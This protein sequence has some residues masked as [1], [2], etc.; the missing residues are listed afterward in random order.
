MTKPDCERTCEQMVSVLCGFLSE[1][2]RES[3]A[4][5]AEPSAE[6]ATHVVV[7]VMRAAAYS[8][9]GADMYEKHGEDGVFEEKELL[10]AMLEN[11]RRLQDWVIEKATL[12]CKRTEALQ[13]C[14]DTDEAY[15]LAQSWN[16][17]AH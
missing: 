11:S 16:R 14:A 1:F 9:A 15:D 5:L 2:E 3:N 10:D 12:S 7:A 6:R 17:G 13:Q 4:F 8:M